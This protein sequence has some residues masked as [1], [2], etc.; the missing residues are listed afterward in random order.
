[1]PDDVLSQGVLSQTEID[2][3]ISSLATGNDNEEPKQ[4][5]VST[6][7]EKIVK[8]YDFKRALRFSKDQIRSLTRIYEN[9][10]RLLTTLFSAHLRTYVHISVVSSG[11]VPYGEYIRSIDSMTFLN[12]IEIPP[13]KGRMIME[14]QPDIAYAMM[15][16]VLGGKG[17]G[18]NKISLLTDIEMKLLTNL[19]QKTLAPLQEAWASISHIE[20]EL[21]EIEVNPQFLQVVSPNET[22]VV[23]SMHAVIGD[24]NGTI[25]IML[26][27]VVL[28]P[29]ISKL[30]AQ[31]W[32]ES[33]SKEKKPE[34]LDALKQ[35]IKETNVE[36]DVELG[37]TYLT[38]RDFLALNKGDVFQLRNRIDEPLTVK[39]AG[40]PKFTG[41][42]GMKHKHLAVQILNM[43]NEGDEDD[44]W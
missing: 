28:E 17:T 1:M 9:F 38:I 31:Y 6:E 29:I 22:V 24:T 36:V 4:A 43:I 12:V 11:Q 39:I 44:E 13:L 3:L 30:S 14:V 27:H 2:D 42:P 25:N 32:M 37:K 40:V 18:M 23:V 33:G 16:R 10:A 5:P 20:P 8:V 19:F 21:S 26:P 7:L 15:D 41:Q 34:A 35:S